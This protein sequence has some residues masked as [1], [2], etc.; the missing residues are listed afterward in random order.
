M[1]YKNWLYNSF[2]LK[3]GEEP[4]E[5]K[6]LYLK[7]R[8]N[9]EDNIINEC[10]EDLALAELLQEQ[11]VFLN[12]IEVSKGI[13]TTAIYVLCSDF[14]DLACADA[15]CVDNNDYEYP[16]EIMELYKFHINDPVWGSSK[17]VA[18]KRN[19]QPH[20]HIKGIMIKDGVWED[21][22]EDLTPRTKEEIRDKKINKI[23]D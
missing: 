9:V 12:N 4:K 2:N 8:K 3:E 14:F 23:L 17:W 11:V 21:W 13:Y 7:H 10:L 6:E 22:M 18:K 15:E 16:S 20:P 5:I 1:K 19:M